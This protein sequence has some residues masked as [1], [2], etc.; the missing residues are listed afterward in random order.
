[1]A[2]EEAATQNG[3]LSNNVI[4]PELDVSKLHALPTEQQDLFLL[5]FVSDLKNAVHDLSSD[6]LPSQQPK[7]KKEVIKV[8]GLGSPVPSRILRNNLGSTL[9]DAFGRG[10]HSLLYETINDIL[11]ILNTGKIDKDI[12]SKHVAVVLLGHIF[13]TA[14]TSAVSLSGLVVQSLL[15]GLKTFS[16]GLRGSIFV[17]LTSIISGLQASTDEHVA[18]DISKSCR[19]SASSDKSAFVQKC[20]F[21]CLRSIV[22]TVNYFDNSSDFENLKIATWKA[23]DSPTPAVRHAAAKALAAALVK[24]YSESGA[25]EVPIIRK[26]KKSKK[27][28]PSADDEEPAERPGSPSS[29]LTKAP[30]R[31]ALTLTDILRTLST[32]F[33]RAST[34][35]R[36]RVGIASCYKQVLIGLP[37]KGVEDNFGRI[38]AQFFYDILNHPSM[39]YNRYRYLLSR[40]LVHNIIESILCSGLLTE[41]AQINVMRYLINDILKNYPRVVT[42][43]REPSK[44]ILTGALDMLNQLLQQLGSAVNVLQDSC[45]EALC[46]VV[47]H[48]SYTVQSHVAQCLRSF[49]LCCPNQLVR[50]IKEVLSQLRKGIDPATEDRQ[51]VRACN[52]QSLGVAAMLQAAN[53]RPVFG[54][55]ETYSQ[56]LTFATDLLKTSATSELRLSATQVQVAWTL[57]GGLMNLGPSFI[58]VHLNQLLLLWRN[59]LPPPLNRENTAQRGQLELSFLCH[60]RECALGGL[61][62]FLDSCASLVTTD[63][64]RRISVMLQNT[65]QFLDNLPSTRHTED[66]AHRLVPDLQL[67]DM[68][69][70][71]RR[72]LLQCYSALAA[73]NHIDVSDVL[74]Q[75]DLVGWSMRIFTSPDRHTPKNLEAS[76][77][78]SASSFEGLW[79]VGDNWGFG[80]T[81]LVR[82]LD[83]YYPQTEGFRRVSAAPTSAEEVDKAL[84]EFSLMP[85]LPALEHDP[86]LLYRTQR[87]TEDVEL[88]PHS[89]ACVDASVKLFSVLLPLQSARVQES[90][91]EQ[92]ATLLSQSLQREPG[93]KAALSVN[94][95]IALLF[96][97]AV[98][99]GETLYASGKLH[100][101]TIG[102]T[103]SDLLKSRLADQDEAV[104]GLSTRALGLVCN[105]GGSQVTNNEVKSLI[106]NIVANRDPYA[107]AGCAVALGSIHAEVGAM[108]SGLHIKSIVGVL[109]SLCNDT[110]PVVHFWAFRGLIQV[111]D[112]AGLS[113]SAYAASTIGMLAQLY[114]SD[115]HNNESQSLSTSNLEMEFSTPLSIAQSVDCIINVLGPDLQDL[116]KLRN[117]IL[118]LLKYLETEESALIRSQTFACLGHFSLFAPAHLQY[119]K[120]VQDLEQNF[121]SKQ[122][123]LSKIS[124]VGISDLMKR[125][126]KEVARVASSKLSDTIW[127]RLDREPDNEVVQSILRNWMQ[128]TIL[129][130]PGTWID[131]YQTI[132][133]RARVKS[134]ALPRAPTAKTAVTDLADE[135]VA[136]FAAA[137]AVAQGEN[138]ETQAEGQDFLRWQTRN[139][140][141]QLLSEALQLVQA[142][143]LPDQVTQAEEDLQEK[144][145]DIIRLAFSAS[146]ANVVELRVLGLRI[147]DQILKLFGK[148]ADPDFLEASLL[149]QYQAQIASALTPAFAADSSPELAAEAIAVCATFVAT[150]IVTTAD[151]MGRIFKVLANGVDS[152]AQSA[153]ATNIGDLKDLSPNAQSMLKMALLSGWA[154]LQLASIDQ[155]YLEDIVQ[156]YIPKLAPLWLE[157]LQEFARLRFEPEISDTLGIDTTASNLDERYSALNRVIRLQ[158]YQNNWLNIV[159]AISALVEKDS[160]AVFEAL[161]KKEKLASQ[162]QVNGLNG[163]KDLSFREE[164]TAFFYILFGLAF[165]ALVTRAR[166]D[167]SQ[168]LSI[169]Q[170]LQKILTPAVSGNAVYGE[171]VFNET[172]DTLDRLAMTGPSQTQSVL[173]DIARNLA[174]DH[175]SAKSTQGRDEQLSEDIEQLFEL[176]RTVILVLTGM[177]PTLED[178][179]SPAARG[180]SIESVTLVHS[181]FQALVD[182]AEVFPSVIRS[183][184][185]ACVFHCYCTM[186]AT[187]ICQDEVLPSLLPDFRKFLQSIAKSKDTHSVQLIR[188]SLHQM[189]FTLSVA[190]RRENDYAIT[191][192]KNTLLSMTVLLSTAGRVLSANDDLIRRALEAIL[193]C[194]Q[195]VGLAK[196]AANC[197]RTLLQTNPKSSCDDATGRLLWP[198]IVLFVGDD[199]TEDPEGV[200]PI[201]AQALVG[202]V[203]TLRKSQRQS[204]MSILI[205]MLLLRAD[206]EQ[207]NGSQENIQKEVASRLLELAAADQQAFRATAGLLDEGTRDTFEQLLRAAGVGRRQD[208]DTDEMNDSK[209]TIELRMDF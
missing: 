146:T 72:R 207:P 88:M 90:S 17:S 139:F 100:M 37:Q 66:A 40:K 181:C 161:D 189:L 154:Q 59:A 148:T 20:A 51:A 202:S 157:S 84:D 173:V 3:T 24:A 34:T 73:L 132:L 22:S 5:T 71:L 19:N 8:A 83:V 184:L 54:S 182:V 33:I 165:E 191:C 192:A 190:Q 134:K 153:T 110:H 10:S 198:R 63:G 49:V 7:I 96:A 188:G 137:A 170:A 101:Q 205:P 46:Q 75:V 201:L 113:F 39:E 44:R 70:I 155:N 197:I 163:H 145:A 203:S 42:E 121:D 6:A 98:A 185:H 106:D 109:L 9:G 180:L 68:S 12:G 77:A 89:V 179:P 41:N 18:R 149:E 186:L 52:G 166:E 107:R 26:P 92:L 172:T 14:G 85:A 93:R 36:A 187:G 118:T 67:Q 125:N 11:S 119:S 160:D 142:Q 108:A 35:N 158:F 152:L 169:L 15:K 30:I 147:I 104:R 112:S 87:S 94:G 95:T 79:E 123:V 177:I 176:T 144:V 86:A 16:V 209:P 168:A 117:L 102:K 97:L 2:S 114:S 129:N 116:S 21:D 133:S 105:L 131:R 194:L 193:D 45:R 23:L 120:Y 28:G 115:S 204:A 167:P 171:V 199:D 138:T 111:A 1:M 143:M 127:S 126:A 58:K 74:A 55:L 50:T 206:T 53:Q 151:R 76:L 27:Q 135:E 31:L 130:D 32:Q 81:S 69:L 29:A 48:P 57:F 195:D 156:P 13:N 183:D 124:I 140:A 82:G 47:R 174:L 159:S 78:T 38:A 91:T 141:M 175:P 103:M 25:P 208:S 56:V 162:N 64:S 122:D 164:P 150:G 136:G 200:R 60:V 65:I 128:Q 61:L 62:S 43:R 178:P 196:V 80:V 4:I 99:S